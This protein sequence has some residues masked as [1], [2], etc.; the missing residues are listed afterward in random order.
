MMTPEAVDR[1]MT[2]RKTKKQ[3]QKAVIVANDDTEESKEQEYV[4]P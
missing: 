4:Q 2:E 1:I 3:E